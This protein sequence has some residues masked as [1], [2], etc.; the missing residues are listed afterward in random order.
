[1]AFIVEDGT[2]KSDATSVTTIAFVDT[3]L[4]DRPSFPGKTEWDAASVAEQQESLIE[5]TQE[6]G[7][8]ACDGLTGTRYDEDQGT[9]WP[10][11]GAY[12]FKAEHSVDDDIVPIPWQQAV[13]ALAVKHRGASPVVPLSQS[14]D[15]TASLKAKKVKLGPLAIDKIYEA[16][17][18]TEDVA[19]DDVEFALA[20][21][22]VSRYRL[23]QDGWIR[24]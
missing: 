12:D 5:A 22:L 21:D 11:R 19:A 23:L 4:A 15:T 16:G 2:A 20:M 10:R 18:K 9:D 24:G 6:L 7:L 8:R 17:G 13:A 14:T 1:M 3:W